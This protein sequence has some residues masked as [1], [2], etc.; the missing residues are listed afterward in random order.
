M[1]FKNRK[2]AGKKLAELL[3]KYKN[4]DSVVYALPR[5]GVLVG[6][7]IAKELNLP[8]DLII[9]R[10][11]GHP[12][13]PEYAIAAVTENGHMVENKNEVLSVNKDWFE[14]EIEKERSE[15][16]RRREQYLS[17]WKSPTVKGKTA[18]IVDDGIA[19]GLTIRAA[20][21]EARHKNPGKIVIAVPVA[22]SETVDLIKREADEFVTLDVFYDFAGSIGAY[23]QDFPQVT[24]KEVISVMKNAKNR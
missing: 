4:S 13:S 15:A 1:V 24:D 23:Y 6:F 21:L 3:K 14:K 22:P 16:K 11:I 9:P 2:E 20:I 5:G 8:L 17:K 19:T 10:K 12:L 18:I 7:E